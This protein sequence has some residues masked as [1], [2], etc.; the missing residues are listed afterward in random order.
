VIGVAKPRIAGRRGLLSSLQFLCSRSDLF[1]EA[2]LVLYSF[3]VAENEHFNNNAMGQFLQLFQV[4]LPRTEANLIQRQRVIEYGL[5]NP[6]EKYQDIAISA[7]DVGINSFREHLLSGDEQFGSKD[8]SPYQP[9]SQDEITGYFRFIIENLITQIEKDTL[10]TVKA[11]SILANS[12]PSLVY[13]GGANLILPVLEKVFK[14][15]KEHWESGLKALKQTL[16]IYKKDLNEEQRL[17][18]KAL[19][20]KYS[21]DNIEY[22]Y[23]TIVVDSLWDELDF[24][25]HEEFNKAAIQKLETFLDEFLPVLD[26]NLELLFQRSQ[27]QGIL[28]GKVLGKRLVDIGAHNRIQ[29]FIEKGLEYISSLEHVHTGQLEVFSSFLRELN[30]V[31]IANKVFNTLFE[32]PELNHLIIYFAATTPISNEFLWKIFDKIEKGVLDVYDLI[33]FK[34]TNKLYTF[35]EEEFDQFLMKTAK[36]GVSGTWVAISFANYK[37][38]FNTGELEKKIN[39]I[40]HLILTPGLWL[41]KKKRYSHSDE[42]AWR[43]FSE[44]LLK[45]G[46][47]DIEL[48]THL[49]VEIKDLIHSSEF[50]VF[51]L[52]GQIKPVL[53]VLLEKYFN[54][55]WPE[56]KKGLLSSGVNKWQDFLGER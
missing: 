18:V 31:E 39:L 43:F 24:S 42:G 47:P 45:L 26:A 52:E 25:D 9:K 53:S 38:R 17:F 22:K 36:Y 19:I 54:T 3:A 20:E 5:A 8:F 55:V 35:S 13:K 16:K 4:F 29:S 12:I 32:N 49:I 30:D 7:M 44:G 28:L 51:S 48:A 46:Y 50:Q 56:I 11:K 23:K 40:R 14:K 15:E 1:D 10:H 27:H 21:P 33:Y 6:S 41:K 37:T 2:A 34:N